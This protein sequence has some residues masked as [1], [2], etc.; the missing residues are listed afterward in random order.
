MEYTLIA[1][2]VILAALGTVFVV[3]VYRTD[4]ALQKMVYDHQRKHYSTS[5]GVP[6]KERY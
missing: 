2:A 5:L 4:K 3:W 1:I 6:P